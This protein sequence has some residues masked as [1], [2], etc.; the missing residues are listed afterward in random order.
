ML[1]A[2]IC[3]AGVPGLVSSR[4]KV[5]ISYCGPGNGSVV[6]TRLEEH[7]TPCNYP[8]FFASEKRKP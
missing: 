5:L 6:K 3:P 8:K 1:R 2:L 4:T 7:W